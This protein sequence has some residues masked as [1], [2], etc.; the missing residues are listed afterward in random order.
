MQPKTTTSIFSFTG[1]VLFKYSKISSS[2]S[3]SINEARLGQASKIVNRQKGGNP[4]K[5]IRDHSSDK[6]VLD[7]IDTY[8]EINV[9]KRLLPGDE[10]DL[11]HR[12][13]QIIEGD[14]LISLESKAEF[15]KIA[16][17]NTL[18]K[19]LVG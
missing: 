7:N 13:M 5:A 9:V 16:Q 2:L 19:F 10:D 3:F 17:K 4:L 18:A 12:F 11:I 1:S 15:Q 6:E 8:F 14:S